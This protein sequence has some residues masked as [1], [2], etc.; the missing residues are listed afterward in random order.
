[1]RL[2]LLAFYIAMATLN[3]VHGKKVLPLAQTGL[4]SAPQRRRSPLGRGLHRDW[5]AM[6]G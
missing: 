1:M 5:R 6:G 3:T 2:V 4:F